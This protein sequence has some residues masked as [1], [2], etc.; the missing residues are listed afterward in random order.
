[1]DLS[2][3]ALQSVVTAQEKSSDWTAPSG[4]KLRPW[5]FGYVSDL[6]SADTF[7]WRDGLPHLVR[8]QCCHVADDGV[9]CRFDGLDAKGCVLRACER[10]V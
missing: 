9:C 2:G 5:H 10:G 7:G 1:M 8:R 4:R 3:N 6:A